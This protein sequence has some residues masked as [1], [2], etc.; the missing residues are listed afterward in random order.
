[1]AQLTMREVRDFIASKF[2]EDNSAIYSNAINRNSAKSIGVFSAPES[3]LGDI[4][5]YGGK[6]L[7]PVSIYP[8]NILVRWTEDSDICEKKANDIYR[9]LS[10]LGNNFPIREKDV[11]ATKI[12]F[13]RM[14]D[15]HPVSLG[16]DKDNV[17]EY[18]I[19]IDIFY[20]N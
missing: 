4:P 14:L 2:S 15:S 9:V 5:T 20:Y 10:G 13:I 18:T 6:T 3:R 17:C 19:R 12:A 16:R 1:M 7:A 11:L 8:V